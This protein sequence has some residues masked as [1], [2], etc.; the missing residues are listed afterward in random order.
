MDQILIDIIQTKFLQGELKCC[1][2]I[3]DFGAV[4]FGGDIELVSLDPGFFDG[5]A[6]LCFV[7]VY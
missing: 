7:S 1:L 4:D 2:G 3:L 6:E 5:F